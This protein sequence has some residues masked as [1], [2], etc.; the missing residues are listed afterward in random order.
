MAEAGRSSR[1]PGARAGAERAGRGLLCHLVFHGASQ[2]AT[3]VAQ[4]VT[5]C[6]QAAT[7]LNRRRA[8][9]REGLGAEVRHVDLR[10]LQPC[11]GDE[12]GV[13]DEERPAIHRKHGAPAH[14]GRPPA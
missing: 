9:E 6:V 1:Q 12:P 8:H 14:L 13:D 3:H 11:V 2:A 7:L 5:V 4:A 10:M